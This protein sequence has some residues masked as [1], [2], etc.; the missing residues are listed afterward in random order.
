MTLL[1][2]IIL[3]IVQGAT[4]FLPISSSGHLVLVPSLLGWD[5]PSEQ[6]FAFNILLQAATLVAILSFFYQDIFTITKATIRALQNSCW[7]DPLAQFGL[8]IFAATIPAVLVGFFFNGFF[9]RVFN[10]PQ[11]T[12]GFLIGTA[13]LLI[14][15]EKAG[16]RE[17][18]IHE[19]TWTDTIW[20]GLF[21]VLALLPGIS[22]SG[23]TITAGML[24]NL[25]R[26]SSA[27]FSFLISI[28][29]MIAAGLNGL[30]KLKVLPE[31]TSS[32]PYFLAGS[33]TAVVVGYFS[34]KWLLNFLHHRSFY[35][36]AIYCVVFAVINLIIMAI[37]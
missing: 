17:R 22:R 35:T 28:P 3:G 1:Q 37:V 27:R 7:E 34:I 4:E 12:A 31:T 33:I 9:N 8:K 13:S 32:L 24:R 16:S 11:A 6:A 18:N 25:D 26:L 10:S 23:S 5:I 2:S 21:Q 14:I 29:L 20:I 36:F 15:G 30:Y 19:I